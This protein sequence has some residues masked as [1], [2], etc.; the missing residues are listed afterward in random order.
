M[1][2]SGRR[3]PAVEA[4]AGRVPGR[5]PE[6][7]LQQARPEQWALARGDGGL[8]QRTHR[9]RSKRRPGDES[10]AG[11]RSVW[12]GPPAPEPRQR[13][14][15]AAAGS[16]AGWRL[17]ACRKRSRPPRSKR[18][19]SAQARLPP[20][21]WLLDEAGGALDHARPDRPA[22]PSVPPGWGPARGRPSWGLAGTA[23]VLLRLAGRRR[24]R[25][26]PRMIRLRFVASATGLGCARRRRRGQVIHVDHLLHSRGRG[27]GREQGARIDLGGWD[28]IPDQVSLPR[29]MG[30]RPKA[31][32]GP[33][34]A[35][36][37]N[38]C[39]QPGG[40][41]KQHQ[42]QRDAISAAIRLH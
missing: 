9:S 5:L 28:H 32:E 8:L 23:V 3:A 39:D 37:G 19:L 14:P 36:G 2:W 41:G 26:G 21:R 1:G 12:V 31:C 11:P 6:P 24:C 40:G 4:V 7:P 17:P 15:P 18:A 20:H 29:R 27:G 22:G 42:Q 30:T 33:A 16:G 10:P 38:R 25:S 34:G 13:A 35:G